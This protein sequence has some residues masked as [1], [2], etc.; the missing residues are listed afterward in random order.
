[1]GIGLR[2]AR[3][4]GRAQRGAVGAPLGAGA[5]EVVEAEA[6]ADAEVPP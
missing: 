1:M 6:L 3:R 5:G 2:R 4:R